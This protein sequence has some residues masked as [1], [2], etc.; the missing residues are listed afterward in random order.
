MF[1]GTTTTK[2]TVITKPLRNYEWE[3]LAHEQRVTKSV[4]DKVLR[5]TVMFDCGT[6]FVTVEVSVGIQNLLY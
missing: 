6:V 2:D 1:L 5:A 4:G 3:T